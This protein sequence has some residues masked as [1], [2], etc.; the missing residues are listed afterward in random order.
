MKTVFQTILLTSLAA[1]SDYNFTKDAGVDP[2][3]NGEPCSDDT[4][5]PK[6]TQVPILEEICNGLDDNGDGQVD[7]GFPDTDKDGI[8]DCVDDVCELEVAAAGT[9]A[10]DTACLAPDIQ[11]SNPWDVAIEWQYTV[12]GGSGVIVMPAIGNLT[13]DNGDGAIDDL[14]DPDIVFTTWGQNHLIA[15]HGDG[16]GV[17][18]QIPGFN[19]NAGV[20]IADVDNDG[21][22]EIIAG[23]TTGQIVALDGA[24]NVEW[25][26]QQF[27]F[28]AYPQPTVADLEGDGDIEVIFDIAIV[29]GS[30]GSTVA[31]LGNMTTSWRAP[32]VA[33]V[34][35]DG[36]QEILLGEH[37]YSPTGVIEFSVPR[38][39]D[40]VFA[41]V[42]DI[43]GDPGGESFGSPATECTLSMTMAAFLEPSI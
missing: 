14:D 20:A 17:I 30:D 37:C 38:L 34:D 23:S 10:I 21:M 26:S 3:I 40:S 18:F 4:G 27:A 43:D 39:G 16:S 9:V 7:E 6:D 15:L 35:N 24:G 41:A 33:D 1:C 36:E 8:A 31:T 25:V 22:P 2:C 11:I 19:G 5:G 13:D 42:A 32:V 28:Q 12:S 29:E